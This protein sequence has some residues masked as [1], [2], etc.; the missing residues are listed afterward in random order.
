ME[1]NLEGLAVPLQYLGDGLNAIKNAVVSNFTNV[2]TGLSVIKDAIVENYENVL[3]GLAVI[4]DEM[5]DNLKNV[6]A[7]LTVVKNAVVD[8]YTK[9]LAGLTVVKDVVVENFKNVTAGLTAVK[10]AVVENW[11]N[12][13][14]GLVS[15]K[16]AIVDNWRNVVAG[17]STVKDAILQVPQN[18]WNLAFA[19]LE[20]LF[21]PSE[22]Y[23]EEK[24]MATRER[25]LFVDCIIETVE[26]M[27]DFFATTAFD[28]PPKFEIDMSNVNSKYDWGGK[29]FIIDFSWYVP[30]KPTV[31][32]L[33]SSILW[34][35]FAWNTFKE[36]PSIINGFG[37]AINNTTDLGGRL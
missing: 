3:A 32:V 11:Q 12:V 2:F 4:K 15:V 14:A 10:N 1:G 21:V 5:V 30:Y 27:Y 17:L 28:V 7:G 29:A 33:L 9:I 18:T 24:I 13:S 31:D 36:L 20:Y 8:N 16:D 6:T 37:S 23:F 35:F 19:G 25:F 22:G 26:S 34:V